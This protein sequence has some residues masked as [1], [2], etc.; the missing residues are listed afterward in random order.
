MFDI[1]SIISSLHRGGFGRRDG[2][3]V[4]LKTIEDEVDLLQ[5]H[6]I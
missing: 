1:L 3:N 6:F 4:F 5:L 2:S